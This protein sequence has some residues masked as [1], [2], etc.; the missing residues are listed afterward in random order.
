M[1]ASRKTLA[2][3]R[4][5]PP[6][7]TSGTATIKDVAA[8]LGVS[9][10]AV[11]RA[12][13][14][15]HHTSEALKERVR[16]A[17]LELGYVPHGAARAMRRKRSLLI[18]LV[19]P[20]LGNRVFTEAASVMAAHCHAAGYQ[21][22]LSVSQL[23]AQIEFEQ[24]KA[25]RE[26]RVDGVIIAPCGDSLPQTRELVSSMPAVQLA[27]R[28]PHFSIPVIGTDDRAGACAAMQHLIQLGHRSIGII[29]GNQSGTDE[30]RFRGAIEGASDMGVRIDNSAIM[31]GALSVAFGREAAA[32]LLQAANRP[33]AILVTNSVLALGM[34]DTIQ[35][36]KISVP[37]ELSVIGFGDPEWFR[38][39]GPGLTT[40]QLPT[41]Q[42]AIACADHL[43]RRIADRD[44]QPG[45]TSFEMLLETNLLLRGSTGPAPK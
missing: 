1:A 44:A 22:I 24:V 42:L 18:G 20:D 21:L 31:R 12:L 33:T 9:F 23:N 32:R 14:D 3:Q 19:I 11:S 39:W 16:K 10:S 29:G 38:L 5:A 7:R 17:A 8:H 41:T 15:H 28:N 26:M 34:V 30:E 45:D 35:R 37:Q 13:S 43:L 25:L 4:Q 27:R 36:R 6:S 2:M 40:V